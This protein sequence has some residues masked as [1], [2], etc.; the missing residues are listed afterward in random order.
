MAGRMPELGTPG[1]WFDISIKART[2][3]AV[4]KA[5]VA[6]L[7]SRPQAPRIWLSH[8]NQRNFQRVCVAD[9]CGPNALS[10][11]RSLETGG[12]RLEFQLPCIVTNEPISLFA[13]PS[14]AS[15][16]ISSVNFTFAPWVRCSSIT[17]AFR[18]AS[19]D[20]TGLSKSISTEP[21][22]RRGC[23]GRGTGLPTS[24][25]EPSPTRV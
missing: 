14:G 9:N 20:F 7:F 1:N 24:P 11:N 17:T 16:S 4:E 18:M 3:G 6:E 13:N 2:C 23:R 10:R 21:K 12:F 5:V 25:V 22:K 19:K 15:A 8:R